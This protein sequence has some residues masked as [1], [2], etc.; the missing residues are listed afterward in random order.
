MRRGRVFI[1]LALILILGLVAAV[2][3]YQQFV[4]SL[5][6]P[7]EEQQATPTPITTVSIVIITQNLD[8]GYVLDANVLGSVPWQIDALTPGMYVE[9]DKDK[10]I[11]R[12]LKFPVEAGTPVM[13]T[14]LLKGEEQLP[15]A[16]S[17]WSL[18]IP[19][20]SIAVSIPI[21]MLSSVSYAPRP[22]DHVDVIVN[23]QFVDLDTDFQSILP[24][25]SGI[26][27]AA[28]PPNPETGKPDP[29]TVEISRG[30]YGRT[31]ID[32]PL[33]QAV[34]I[35]PSERQR[36]RMVSHMLLQ[37]VI[38]LQVGRFELAGEQ[39][40][41]E[42][43][44][45]A[46]EGAEAQQQ[47]QVVLPEVI[48]LIVN[49]QDAVTLNYLVN[50]GAKLT[51]ALRNIRDETRLELSPV[52]LNYLLSQYRIEVPLRLPYGLEPRVDLPQTQEGAE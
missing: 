39:A 20:G 7:T 36:A 6:A 45:Q 43:Q 14:L 25:L 46:E 34:F 17:P 13:E 48:T 44:Q 11:G 8:S 4:G 23:L 21:D 19:K 22:G 38:V 29:L 2:V 41:R 12:Q 42:Q 24:N 1:Y 30:I 27:L 26:V 50:A 47:P 3:L 5:F 18:N 16:G 35:I 52:T 33:G 37:N 49:P 51:L 10:L 9:A 15:M 40:Q 32:P 28:G 31:I